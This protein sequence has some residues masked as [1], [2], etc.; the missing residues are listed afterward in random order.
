VLDIHTTGST[1]GLTH[2]HNHKHVSNVLCYDA[3]KATASEGGRN[4]SASL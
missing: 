2:Q 3:M 4:L 1:V